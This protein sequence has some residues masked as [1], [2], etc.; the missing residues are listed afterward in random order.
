[1][2]STA[3][4]EW[5]RAIINGVTADVEKGLPVYLDTDEQRLGGI[6]IYCLDCEKPEQAIEA[7]LTAVRQTCTGAGR[8]GLTPLLG[9]DDKGFPKGIAFLAT[10]VLAAYDMGEDNHAA[11]NNFFIRLR[12]R[13]ALPLSEKGRPTGL[14]KGFEEALWQNWN[15]WLISRRWAPTAYPGQGAVQFIHYARSQTLLRSVDRQYLMDHYAQDASLL[16]TARRWD[17]AQHLQWLVR[18]TDYGLTAN[19]REILE[20]PDPDRRAALGNAVAELVEDLDLTQTLGVTVH[21][22]GSISHKLPPL[23][24]H[25]VRV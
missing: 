21:R 13:L 5:N 19:L 24:G 14:D 20:S 11:A 3:Y 18:H 1:M 2:V 15:Q 6:G 16:H 25:V 10:L 9:T 7:F 23:E 8:V 12:E 17:A 4:L 22:G